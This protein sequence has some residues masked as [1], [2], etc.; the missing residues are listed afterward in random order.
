MHLEL[1]GNELSGVDFEPADATD[2][3]GSCFGA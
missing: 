2:E 3:A 1:F